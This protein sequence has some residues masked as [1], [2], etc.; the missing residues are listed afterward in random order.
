[1]SD[2]RILLA[3]HNAPTR[4]G[5]RLALRAPGLLVAA[6]AANAEDLIAVARAQEFDVAL[7]AADLPGGGLTAVLALG[8]EAPS[9]RAIMLGRETSDEEFIEAVRAGA[10]GYLGHDIQP[11]RL[12][13]VVRAAAAGEAVVPRCF[14]AALLDEIHGRERLRSTVTRH[15]SRPVTEREWEVLRLLADNLSTA[16]LAQRIGISEVTVRRHVSSA[17]AKL[18]VPNRE[19]AVRLLR[20]DA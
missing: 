18:G 2:V 3:V 7:V 13:A 15:A 5:L 6:E 8:R 19:A 20:S 4:A 17:V 16:Q 9:V 12:A 11:D 1:V 10:V 14:A